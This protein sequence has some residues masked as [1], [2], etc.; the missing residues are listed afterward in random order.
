M[1]SENYSRQTALAGVNKV[2][3]ADLTDNELATLARSEEAK[4]RAA[5]AE[6]PNT[7]LTSLLLLAQDVAPAVRAGVAR[8]PRPDM[9]VELR[10]DLAKDKSSEVVYAVIDN[11][12]TPD[13]ILSKFTRSFHRDYA[14]A[15]KEALNTRKTAARAGVEL[16]VSVVQPR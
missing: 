8:N 3:A 1:F 12:A 7:P 5:V 11:P 14:I 15:A 2:L 4:V 13:S 9:P 6:R 16:N 10:Q